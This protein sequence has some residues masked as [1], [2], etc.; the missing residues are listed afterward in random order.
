MKKESKKAFSLA[1]M[2]VVMLILT[3][4]LAASLP[5]ITKQQHAIQTATTGGVPV[6]IIIAYAGITVPTGW[7]PCDGSSIARATYAD[8][9]AAISTTYGSVSGSTFNLPD[10]RGRV[11]LGLDSSTN[12][13]SADRVTAAAADSLNGSGGEENHML[14]IGEMPSHNHTGTT[15]TQG[16]HTHNVAEYAGTNSNIPGY[17]WSNSHIDASTSGYI[18]G[19]TGWGGAHS[20]SISINNNGSNSSHNNMPPYKTFNYIIKF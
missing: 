1:E 9:F 4:A 3:L 12:M 14:T 8:L 19:G 10:L 15:D 5:I 6:G 16:N 7:L 2:M 20:H 17:T 13:G 18:S 11:P